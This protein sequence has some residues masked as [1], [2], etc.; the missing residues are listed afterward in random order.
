ML[1]AAQDCAP[2]GQKKNAGMRT[3]A[4]KSRRRDNRTTLHSYC[5]QPKLQTVHLSYEAVKIPLKKEMVS[6]HPATQSWS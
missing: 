3:F 4:N 1:V 6:P 2:G 5:V